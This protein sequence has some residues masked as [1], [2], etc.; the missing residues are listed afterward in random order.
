MKL[1][2]YFGIQKYAIAIVTDLVFS[3]KILIHGPNAHLI[4]G[5]EGS[6]FVHS[7]VITLT[8][9]RGD[10][11]ISLPGNIQLGS[12]ALGIFGNV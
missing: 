3:F 11:P 2:V 9:N 6:P 10:Q 8:G 12:K 5:S 7:A 1:C 4:V